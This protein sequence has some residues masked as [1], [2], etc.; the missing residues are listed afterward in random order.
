MD[1][2]ELHTTISSLDEAI[3]AADETVRR[4]RDELEK[5]QVPSQEV[6]L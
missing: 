1:P 6:K 5:T 2:T 4:L 3:T